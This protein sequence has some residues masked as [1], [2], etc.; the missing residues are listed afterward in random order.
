MHAVVVKVKLPEG[1]SVEEGRKQLES[2]VL[3]R[4]RQNPGVL[5]GYWLRPPQGTEGLSVVVF[6]TEEN[7]RKAAAD[8]RV[9]PGVEVL[10]TE[11]REVVASI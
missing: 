6:D 2:E 5:H 3:P 1:R 7:A 9:P 4:V 11:V 8:V 10:D